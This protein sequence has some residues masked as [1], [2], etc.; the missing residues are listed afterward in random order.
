MMQESWSRPKEQ[1]DKAKREAKRV[2]LPCFVDKSQGQTNPCE[3]I[4]PLWERLGPEWTQYR[5]HQVQRMMKELLP[6]GWC[7]SAELNAKD[8]PGTR[9][10]RNERRMLLNAAPSSDFHSDGGTRIL[11][12]KPSH[13]LR[14]MMLRA[15]QK[16]CKAGL[17]WKTA[18]CG[19]PLSVRRANYYR[20]SEGV[21]R[22]Q[23]QRFKKSER[24][25]QEVRLTPLGDAIVSRYRREL[26]HNKP[27]RWDERV[28]ES[29]AEAR[30]S[31]ET[32]I[33]IFARNAAEHLYKRAKWLDHVAKGEGMGC[34]DDEEMCG[35]LLRAVREMYP[36]VFSA[37]L[38]DIPVDFQAALDRF[39][40]RLWQSAPR[41]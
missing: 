19:K 22:E 27:I 29:L 18:S 8:L 32:L 41:D 34:W 25:D 12:D 35:H 30:K 33:A 13:S 15:R 38:V 17:V 16:L 37:T 3:V 36:Q 9:L 5:R 1:T 14:V 2:P 31:P 24:Y 20:D 11:P 40:Q 23:R 28:T 10:G 39:L 6:C 4:A 7:R 26:E 21:E